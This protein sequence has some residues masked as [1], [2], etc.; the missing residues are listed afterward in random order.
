MLVFLMN[1]GCAWWLLPPT[2]LPA[3]I[4]TTSL[5]AAVAQPVTLISLDGPLVSP[6]AELSGMD[7][8]GDWL[9]LLPQYPSRFD[10]QLFALHRQDIVDFLTGK[11]QMSLNPFSI[12]FIDARIQEQTLIFNGYEGIT[13][14][15]DRVYLTVEASFGTG[16]MGYLV[17][18]S[19]APD[20]TEIRLDAT[21]VTP[22]Q[23][24][25]SLS[26]ISDETIVAVGDQLATIYEA[27]GRFVNAEPVVHFFDAA[28]LAPVGT[29][30]LTPIEYR[31]TDGTAIDNLGRFW[32]INY[33]YPGDRALSSILRS[34]G[35]TIDASAHPI[36]RLLE[37]QFTTEGVIRTATPPLQLELL[38]DNVA[39]NWEGIVRL[40]AEGLD[41]F[42]LVT[43]AFPETLFAFVPKLP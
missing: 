19:I 12:P 3:T 33:F 14:L 29:L 38:P 22:I 17:A 24:Q 4:L 39:R 25:A 18:G 8:Y 9:I 16:G 6:R 5:S 37:L 32:V 20:L 11:N 35:A 28:T 1:S 43:D 2:A 23:P 30:P 40:Q 41:G 7:W 10:N 42:L 31:V 26:N 34:R 27:N 21:Q 13:F 36:E 15:G